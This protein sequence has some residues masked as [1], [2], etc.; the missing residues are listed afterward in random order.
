MD[1]ANR[2]D[3]C[4]C[5]SGKKYKKCHGANLSMAK[6]GSA[7]VLTGTGNKLASLFNR[8]IQAQIQV[9]V[10]PPVDIES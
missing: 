1:K 7:Q 2:N 3:P 10:A 5:K 9:P 8:N 6:I 4:P